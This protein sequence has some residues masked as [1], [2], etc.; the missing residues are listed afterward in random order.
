MPF[1]HYAKIGDNGLPVVIFRL[2]PATGIEEIYRWGQGWLPRPFLHLIFGDE[3]ERDD[4]YRLIDE[5]VVTTEII[6]WEAARR[7]EV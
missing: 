4:D 6:R 7:R 2:D 5:A 3:D 1:D